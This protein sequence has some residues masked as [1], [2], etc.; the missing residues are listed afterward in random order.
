[1]LRAE[2]SY[3]GEETSKPGK[4]RRGFREMLLFNLF[5]NVYSLSNVG[6]DIVEISLQFPSEV[7]CTTLTLFALPILMHQ[8]VDL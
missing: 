3:G 4:E 1:M 8:A 2:G 7:P 5:H 6:R